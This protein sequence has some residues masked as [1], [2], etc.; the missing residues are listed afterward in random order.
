VTSSQL[1]VMRSTNSASSTQTD[2]VSREQLANALHYVPCVQAS[3][4]CTVKYYCLRYVI[5]WIRPLSG[6]L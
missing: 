4:T 3:S 6:T 2:N 1:L 5:C